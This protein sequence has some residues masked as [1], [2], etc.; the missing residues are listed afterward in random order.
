MKVKTT[1]MNLP[2]KGENLYND[3]MFLVS[4]LKSPSLLHGT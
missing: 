2:P 4:L 3:N 1:Q